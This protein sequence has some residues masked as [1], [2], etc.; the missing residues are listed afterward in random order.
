MRFS[1]IEAVLD[2]QHCV[3]DQ[4]PDGLDEVHLPADG[5]R[6]GTLYP[7]DVQL[8]MSGDFPGI[9]PGDLVHNTM[10][11]TLASERMKKLLE[12]A[13]TAPIEFLPF[14]LVNH[15]G[16]SAG[17]FYIANVLAVSDCVDRARTE[18]VEDAVNQGRLMIIRKLVLDDARIDPKLNLFRIAV[19]PSVLIIRED[20][21]RAIEAA[22]MTGIRYLELGTKIRLR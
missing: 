17:T 16:R 9:R 20:L 13:C 3:V 10:G 7:P 4:F 22:G 5:E 8:A 18:G 1:I 21:R 6:V 15:K 2:D 19:L 14:A 12:D 11:Y